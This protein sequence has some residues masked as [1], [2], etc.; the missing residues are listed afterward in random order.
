MSQFE[1][2]T[3]Y[4]VMLNDGLVPLF[5]NQD[6][7]K[8]KKITGALVDGGSRILE[9]TNRGDYALEVFSSLQKYCKEN[10]PELIIGVGSVI[11]APT[12]AIYIES[13]ANFVVGPSLNKD[14]ALLCNR[15][16]VAY[17][18]G[19]ATVNEIQKAEELGME[20]VKIF[21]GSTLGGP[22]FIKNVLGPMPWVKLMPTGGVT[23]E[24]KNIREWFDAGAACVGIGSKLVSKDLILKEDYKTIAKLTENVLQ[25]I[26]SARRKVSKI[27]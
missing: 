6:I 23:T 10:Y 15:R 13:G 22:K 8:A 7:E 9:F 5:F 20:I 12:A 21:P 19:A 3:V 4:N 17:I 11:D 18:P 16:K 24:E 14:I 25:I 27:M 26:K 1:R 2:I